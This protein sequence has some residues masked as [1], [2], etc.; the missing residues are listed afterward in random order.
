MR[1]VNCERQRP[2]ARGERRAETLMGER[3]GAANVI[4]D[5]QSGEDV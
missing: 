3:R 5:T 4:G 1:L 2:G